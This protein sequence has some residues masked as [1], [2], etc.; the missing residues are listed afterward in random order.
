MI[1]ELRDP[2]DFWKV[3]KLSWDRPSQK[4]FEGWNYA[5][6]TCACS[7]SIWFLILLLT[8]IRELLKILDDPVVESWSFMSWSASGVY[9]DLLKFFEDLWSSS[10]VKYDCLD[11]SKSSEWSNRINYLSFFERTSMRTL[12][13]LHLQSENPSNDFEQ[14][15]KI[16]FGLLDIRYS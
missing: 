4:Y 2:H 16:L 12:N 13:S 15:E 7:L 11:S 3:G 8:L 14:S 1:L 10:S 9:E 5:H 6:D